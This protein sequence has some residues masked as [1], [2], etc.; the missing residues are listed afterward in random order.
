VAIV[1]F[2]MHLASDAAPSRHVHPERRLRLAASM[3]L[4][5]DSHGHEQEQDRLRDYAGTGLNVGTWPDV[6]RDPLVTPPSRFFRRNHAPIPH[7]DLASW[8]LV[9]EG[10]VDRPGTF[11]LDALTRRFPRHE[12][13]STLVCAGL[14]R[15][16]LMAVAALPGELPWGAD[17]ASTGRWSG[18]RLADVLAECGLR[19]GATHVEFVGLD[20][21]VR[22]G[23]AFGFGG[24][25]D[26]RKA[27]DTDVLL[28]TQLDGEPI[29]REHGFPLR[30][31][32]PGWIGARS[33]KWLGRIMVLAAESTNYFQKH[34]YR[35]AKTPGAH[36]PTDVTDGV[37]MSTVALNAV[38]TEPRADAVVRA[39]EV[40]VRGWA[41]GSE[42]RPVTAVEVSLDG[43]TRWTSARLVRQGG[44]WSWS[45]WEARL[46]LPA[47]RH[48]L[49]AR[50]HDGASRMPATREE[51]WNVKGYGN[52]SWYRVVISA[53]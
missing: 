26:V 37:A 33:V 24:S 29:P 12:V 52:N 14:R 40:P 21:V 48:E 47:G 27:L 45:F 31:V 18:V 28:A 4:E 13:T 22:H 30:A 9:I 17:A 38:I 44:R 6:A 46:E 19:N 34:A 23:E 39:G 5:L 8:R 41:I 2:G 10:L 3:T 25:I 43:G 51:C 50:A 53:R 15:A 42:G 32:V 7:V 36:G 16:E 1:A 11:T 49:L 35:V 20:R